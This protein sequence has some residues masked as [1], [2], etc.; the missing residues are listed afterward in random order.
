M[1]QRVT[2]PIALMALLG[3]L[4]LLPFTQREEPA[5]RHQ[6]IPPREFLLVPTLVAT[7]DDCLECHQNVCEQHSVSPHAN[8][9][10]RTSSPGAAEFFDGQNWNDSA[11]QPILS[12][13]LQEGILQLSHREHERRWAIEW[14]FGSG[15]H[16]QTPLITWT[17]QDGQSVSIEHCASAYGQGVIGATL[18]MEGLADADGMAA[19]GGFRSHEQTVNCFGCHSGSVPVQNGQIQF[20]QVVPGVQCSRCHQDAQQHAQ[21]MRDGLP[22]QIPAF[23]SLTPEESIN[24]CGECHRRSDELGGQLRPDDPIL[25]RFAPVGLSQSACFQKQASVRT[26]DGHAARFDCL[27]CHDP[28]AAGITDWQHHVR[29]CLDC[30]DPQEASLHSCSVAAQDTNCIACHMPAVPAGEHLKFTDH[31]IRRPD[32]DSVAELLKSVLSQSEQPATIP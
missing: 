31:W 26:S 7:G 8:T 27:S 29:V 22:L 11:G 19:L 15:R 16:A 4:T 6:L 30:H 3:G 2:I 28:H 1:K 13:S 21:R 20:D 18:E 25:P 12:W 24:R 17:N 10:K 32:Q 23:R 9:L 5:L 14:I